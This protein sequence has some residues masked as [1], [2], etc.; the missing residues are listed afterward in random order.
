MRWQ[1]TTVSAVLPT[2]L[3]QNRMRSACSLLQGKRLVSSQARQEQVCAEPQSRRLEAHH[4]RRGR[5]SSP[6]NDARTTLG[7]S[8]R[9]VVAVLLRRCVRSVRVSQDAQ[10]RRAN[11]RLGCATVEGVR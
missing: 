11:G 3:Q 4:S 1:E 9:R 10:P 5:H 2:G 8:Q 7:R 6:A